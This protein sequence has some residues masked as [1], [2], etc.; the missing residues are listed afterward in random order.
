VLPQ[1][2][3]RWIL[4]QEKVHETMNNIARMSFS[5]MLSPHYEDYRL[6]WRLLS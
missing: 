5:W 1:L 2:L 4:S 3:D 6:F